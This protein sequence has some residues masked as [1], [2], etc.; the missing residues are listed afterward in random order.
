MATI[1]RATLDTRHFAFE[2]Y[3]ATEDGARRAIDAALAAHADQYRLPSPGWFD[4]DDIHVYPVVIDA[5][6]RDGLQISGPGIAKA[7]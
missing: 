1:Y 4:D 2:A 7:D 3:G 5:G 6:Y